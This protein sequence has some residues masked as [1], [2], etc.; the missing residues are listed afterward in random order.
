MCVFAV[1]YTDQLKNTVTRSGKTI[2]KMEKSIAFAPSEV[3]S[4]EEGDDHSPSSH[5]NTSGL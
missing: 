3:F 5:L 1:L 4:E 2:K